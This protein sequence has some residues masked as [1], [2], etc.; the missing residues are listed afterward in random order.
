MGTN[1]RLW[2]D[3]ER[4]VPAE[5]NYNALSSAQAINLL[6][7]AKDEG[8][9]VELISFDHDLGMAYIEHWY[10]GEVRLTDDTS[11]RVLT[12]IIEKDFWPQEIRFHTANRVGHEWLVGTAV[13]YA[14]ATTNVVTTDFWRAP[15]E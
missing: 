15:W 7:K 2:I 1:M 3:D 10:N 9:T 13:R 8:T 6:Q 4:P 14:P 11:R 12:W 5:F